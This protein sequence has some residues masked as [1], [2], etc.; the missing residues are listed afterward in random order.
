MLEKQKRARLE[1]VERF[2][3]HLQC[4]QEMLQTC[5]SALPDVSELDTKLVIRLEPDSTAAA[6]S[7]EA[8]SISSAK[9]G[10]PS[11]ADEDKDDSDDE[12]GMIDPESIRECE[13]LDKMMCEIVDAMG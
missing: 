6:G 8:A 1:T 9:V 12:D 7:V 3:K 13:T 5:I 2:Q 10:T 4:V 11:K